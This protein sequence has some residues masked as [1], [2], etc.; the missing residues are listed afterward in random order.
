MKFLKSKK[1]MTLVEVVTGLA[2]FSLIVLFIMIIVTAS[3]NN[4]K[5]NSDLKKDIKNAA[6]DIEYSLSDSITDGDTS[7]EETEFN[8]DFGNIVVT[9]KGKF[10]NSV[11]EE[12]EVDFKYFIPD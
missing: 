12:K 5:K 11:D 10:I 4:I 7:S 2:V 1:G 9:S 3:L 8:V 6:A